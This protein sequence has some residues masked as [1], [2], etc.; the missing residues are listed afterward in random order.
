MRVQVAT[1]RNF[2]HGEDL[3]FLNLSLKVARASY[4]QLEQHVLDNITI[5]IIMFNDGSWNFLTL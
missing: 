4:A 3:V 1:F 2:S 5:R